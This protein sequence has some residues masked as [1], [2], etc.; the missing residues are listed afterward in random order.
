MDPYPLKKSCILGEMIF[1]HFLQSIAN[2]DL[3][4]CKSLAQLPGLPPKLDAS[5]AD[6]HMALKSIHSL[7]TKKNLQLVILTPQS[8]CLRI[9]CRGYVPDTCL[10]QPFKIFSRI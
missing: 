2:L 5:H 1:E 9:G 6:Y 8:I 7:S 4:E 3:T 10:V